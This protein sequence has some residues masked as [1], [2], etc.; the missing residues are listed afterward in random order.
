[1][2]REPAISQ[3]EPI[4]AQAAR[5]EIKSYRARAAPIASKA[6]IPDLGQKPSKDEVKKRIAALKARK[7]VTAAALND[8]HFDPTQPLRLIAR[9]KPGPGKWSVQA[10]FESPIT[11]A[12]GGFRP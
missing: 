5:P 4:L 3:K 1:M 8:L 12:Q 10:R 9:K 6:A 11:C 2:V 7:P